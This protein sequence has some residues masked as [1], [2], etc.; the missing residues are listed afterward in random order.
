MPQSV[1]EYRKTTGNHINWKNQKQASQKQQDERVQQMAAQPGNHAGNRQR[2]DAIHAAVQLLSIL[3]SVQNTSASPAITPRRADELST[4]ARITR[5]GN[6]E[7]KRRVERVVNR[8]VN[9]N[10]RQHSST[11]NA[12]GTQRGQPNFA[13]SNARPG[14]IP[15]K[16]ITFPVHSAGAN[17]ANLSGDIIPER[18]TSAQDTQP[19]LSWLTP[20]TTAE[21]QDMARLIPATGHPLARRAKRDIE[22]EDH[23]AESAAEIM[24]HQIDSVRTLLSRAGL[25]HDS[26]VKGN[27]IPFVNSV[28]RYL[29]KSPSRASKLAQHLFRITHEY[30]ERRNETLSESRVQS[31]I[32][33]WLSTLTFGSPA[34]TFVNDQLSALVQEGNAGTPPYVENSRIRLQYLI[35][36]TNRWLSKPDTLTK[37]YFI[38]KLLDVIA[39]AIMWQPTDYE[40]FGRTEICSLEWGYMHAALRFAKDIGLDTHEWAMQDAIDIGQALATLCDEAV[41][42]SEWQDY[43]L[44]PAQ[45]HLLREGKEVT[46]NSNPDA[47]VP[48]ISVREQVS[49]ETALRLFFTARKAERQRNDPFIRLQ[50]SLEN[51]KTRPALAMAILQERCPGL[52]TEKD[53]ETKA[54]LYLDADEHR[55]LILP[56]GASFTDPRRKV[57]EL[58]RINDE[59]AAQNRRI[60]EQLGDVDRILLPL[61]F[62]QLS[63]EESAFIEHA[64]VHKAEATFS[65]A[66]AIRHTL[67]GGNRHA[68]EGLTKRMPRK[69]ELFSAKHGGEERIYALYPKQGIG[70]SLKRVDRNQ[71]FYLNLYE[72]ITGVSLRLDNDY[73]LRVTTLRAALKDS[74]SDISVLYNAIRQKH[75]NQIQEELHA[76]GYAK[77]TYEKVTDFALSLIPFYECGKNIYQGKI[78][79]A[80]I[81]CTVDVL[82]LIPLAVPAGRVVMK[83]G[84]ALSFSALRALRQSSAHN[85]VRQMA[86]A[87]SETLTAGSVAELATGAARVFDPGIELIA[88]G[89][90]A[91]MRRAQ[92]FLTALR[93]IYPGAEKVATALAHR[94]DLLVEPATSGIV[95]GQLPG[96]THSWDVVKIG[97]R[98][99]EDVF[100][101][102]IP[103]TGDKFGKKYYRN[104]DGELRPVYPGLGER[105]HVMRQQ[106]LGGRGSKVVARTWGRVRALGARQDAAGQAELGDRLDPHE[107]DPL[108]A[109]A[110]PQESE[111]LPALTLSQE[112]EQLLAPA[113]PQA[114]YANEIGGGAPHDPLPSNLELQQLPYDALEQIILRCDLDTLVNLSKTNRQLH[115]AV[116][117]VFKQNWKDKKGSAAIQAITQNK[118]ELLQFLSSQNVRI[119]EVY[120][121]I[122][123]EN[124]SKPLLAYALEL[125]LD[126][127]KFKLIF[128]LVD[129]INGKILPNPKYP[130]K[131]YEQYLLEAAVRANNIN[132][133][134]ALLNYERYEIPP[135]HAGI[136]QAAAEV[137]NLDMFRYLLDSGRFDI[138]SGGSNG[139]TVLRNELLNRGNSDNAIFQYIISRN[140][141]EMNDAY[142][143]ANRSLK[144]PEKF[145]LWIADPR[146]DVNIE[147][148]IGNENGFGTPLSFSILHALE[149][150]ISLPTFD[151]LVAEPRVDVLK[152]SLWLDGTRRTP[153]QVLDYY[154]QRYENLNDDVVSH[155]RQ[156]LHDRVEAADAL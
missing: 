93:D 31:K 63:A 49:R 102:V 103:Q 75:E 112:G 56:R 7:L 57:I 140:D 83:F 90:K 100:V 40:T 34:E 84:E 133:V 12:P 2:H 99:G 81:P 80:V 110:Q 14:S 30:G 123:A 115:E 13:F 42:P 61:A 60:A 54:D 127:E 35:G 73:R 36:A 117:N 147:I 19:A 116:S 151:L 27:N 66:H 154:V 134:I 58:P 137:K 120:V 38:E 59:F 155:I 68:I 71:D 21:S 53:Y 47:S 113:S 156:K 10:A 4:E 43:F 153:E 101:R 130:W 125:N 94:A 50:E 32:T 91:G 143:F 86:L 16:S 1:T 6:L 26:P 76:Y 70:Y 48:D 69:L 3:S 131:G 28:V 77:T 74:A 87:G 67:I 33:D 104:V 17:A 148:P 89:G 20:D 144:N 128:D 105:L 106:G 111:Q 55:C 95:K 24:R 11:G 92:K 141:I 62:T 41:V 25:P 72:E 152:T 149:S 51:F 145:R 96:L 9:R 82:G 139:W 146:V 109:P 107:V 97:Q 22:T 64:E 132:A 39:P 114:I 5:A 15:E 138:N 52:G 118:S 126:I 85:I 78:E 136:L 29:S 65:A 98:K 124:R 108:R 23:S 18:P 121:K 79:E 119:D 8:E 122:G 135:E 150:P 37:K 45:L 44:L 142:V 46:G 88:A 129:K